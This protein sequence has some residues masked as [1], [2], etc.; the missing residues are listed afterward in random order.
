VLQRP[1]FVLRQNDDLPCP[2]GESLEQLPRR[3]F[4]SIPGAASL[5]GS[6]GLSDRSRLI[7]LRVRHEVRPTCSV[8]FSRVEQ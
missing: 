2:L 6:K 3:S 7:S 1:G 4:R 8:P 5:P